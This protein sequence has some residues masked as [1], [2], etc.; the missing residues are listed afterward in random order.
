ME[1]ARWHLEELQWLPLQH[2]G[3]FPYRQ[4]SQNPMLKSHTLPHEEG[5][6]V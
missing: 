1:P 3:S 5:C 4:S 6:M 2:G